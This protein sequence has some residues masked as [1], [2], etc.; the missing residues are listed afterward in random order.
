MRGTVSPLTYYFVNGLAGNELREK[1][2]DQVLA[3]CCPHRFSDDLPVEQRF[4]S[5]INRLG[6]TSINHSARYETLSS[7][8]LG[9]PTSYSGSTTVTTRTATIHTGRDFQGNPLQENHPFY[10]LHRAIQD[11]RVG[12]NEQ[13]SIKS[14][15]EQHFLD[16]SRHYLAGF[17]SRFGEICPQ[18]KTPW[19]FWLKKKKHR[20]E[21]EAARKAWKNLD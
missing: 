4:H 6:T 16:K 15:I 9:E 12:E 3:I 10:D 11:F 8:I 14:N 5:D 1:Y 17:L 18:Q 7:K 13:L 21:Y 19:E 2:R 20:E